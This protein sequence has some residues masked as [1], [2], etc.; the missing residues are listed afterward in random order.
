MFRY[1][2][3]LLAL[4]LSGC[5][6]NALEFQ[7]SGIDTPALWNSLTN[8]NTQSLNPSSLVLHKEAEIDQLWWHNFDDPVL[9]TLI[10]E[11]LNTNKTLQ[12]AKERVIEAQAGRLLVQSSL[13]PQINGVANVT[14]QNLGFMTREKTINVAQTDIQASWELDLFGR[15]QAKNAQASA[16]LQ[17]TEASQQAVRVGLLAEVARTYFDIHTYKNQI[18]VT[19]KN[20][21]IQQKTLAL[22]ETQKQGGLA[23]D[24]DIERT[25]AQISMTEA[26]IP[27]L[28]MAYDATLN[29]MNVLL[30]YQPNHKDYL[31]KKPITLKPLNQ[32]ILIAAPAKTLE[33][34]PDIRVAEREF[35]ASIESTKIAKASLFPNISLTALFGIQES[36]QYSSTPWNLG[37][38]LVQPILNFGRIESQINSA[39]SRQ[40]QAFLNYQQVVLSALENMENALSSYLYET[41][42]NTSL[43]KGMEHT[44]K[45]AMLAQQYYDTGYTGLLE[46][47]IAD[48]NVLDAE[49][50]VTMSEIALRKNMVNIYTAAGGGWQDKN[51]Q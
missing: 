33:A 20:L 31:F 17:S 4:I 9:N 23:N 8:K 47:L 36:T 12:I 45:A 24:F 34:R 25:K 5:H 13:L 38:G 22:I 46:V 41:T 10:Q 30:G 2:F 27:V 50:A 40:K 28:K 43:I 37:A 42:R 39:N 51:K 29:R 21:A 18:R 6:N 11:A 7:S 15:N 26:Q 35:V 19:E 1:N 48:K 3:F 49:L 32:N 44:N 14:R 16:I